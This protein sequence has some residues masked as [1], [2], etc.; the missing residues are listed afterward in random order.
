MDIVINKKTS[1]IQSTRKWFILPATLA[2][3][4]VIHL[5]AANF[6][7]LPESGL[8]ESSA[9]P[10]K[11]G[12][13]E[14]RIS[15]I[16]EFQ[17]RDSI[18]L[19]APTSGQVRD[20]SVSLGDTVHVGSSVLQ[21]ADDEV[22]RRLSEAR[23][24]LQ[25]AR[26][27]R[28]ERDFKRRLD[29]RRQENV[30][31]DAKGEAELVKKEVDAKTQLFEDGIVSALEIERMRVRLQQ[32]QRT[33]ELETSA[34]RD[35][36]EIY[37][38]QLSIDDERIINAQRAFEDAQTLQAALNVKSPIEGKIQ[39][40]LVSQG[41]VLTRGAKLGVVSDVAQMIARVRISQGLANS[42][43][44]GTRADLRWEGQTAPGTVIRIDS[45]VV[46][47]LVA[48]DVE[49]EA[50]SGPPPRPSQSVSATL[51]VDSRPDSL[52]VERSAQTIPNSA[53]KFE[54]QGPDGKRRLGEIKFGVASDEF[55]EILSGATKQDRLVV[56]LER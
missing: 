7:L 6:G 14:Y 4:A 8:N 25:S 47:G 44:I 28:A 12:T 23:L 52:F 39:E 34:L 24:E 33:L 35:I 16:G 18:T 53:A 30:I 3:L 41:E 43:S 48:I 21:L 22:E 20:I 55:V 15:G 10:I 46:Q 50:G 56:A 45:K 27:V 19:A 1:P 9:I 36:A 42:V 5:S 40:L 49:F 32:T 13:F 17:P 29:I 26:S 51:R 11:F 38:S 54:V 37:A 2:G 31:A